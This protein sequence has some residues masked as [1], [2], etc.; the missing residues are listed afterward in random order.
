MP[1]EVL[2]LEGKGKIELTG[3]LGDVMKESARIAISYARSV[4]DKYGINPDFFEKKD[5]HVHAPEGA[6]PKDGPSAG[7][8]LATALISALSSIPVR[9]DVAMT[10]EI[11]LRGKVLAIGGL[12]EKTM[13]AY[14]AGVKTVIVPEANRGDMDEVED[15][16]K[17]NVEFVFAKT[18]SDVLDVALVKDKKDKKKIP[19]SMMEDHK[20]PARAVVTN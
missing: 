5:I 14:K 13:A 3:S 8:T 15:I 20:K 1:L 17:E 18:I 2:V 10:G 9:C 16:V 19:A 7:V 12:R 4:A 11:T 6:V